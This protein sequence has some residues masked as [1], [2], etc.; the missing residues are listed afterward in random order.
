LIKLQRLN[1]S[2]PTLSGSAPQSQDRLDGAG[3]AVRLVGADASWQ[4]SGVEPESPGSQ[5]QFAI[6]VQRHD[7]R[8]TFGRHSGNHRRV[9]L[10]AKMRFPRVVSRVKQNHPLR[11]LWID[12][13][14]SIAFRQVAGRTGERAVFAAVGTTLDRRDD[15]LQVE[16]ITAGGLGRA[17]VLAP[18]SGTYFH[19]LAQFADL[20]LA[21]ASPAIQSPLL[22]GEDP[23]VVQGEFL[24]FADQVLQFPLFLAAEFTLVV[25]LHE[26]IEPILLVRR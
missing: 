21:H 1:R 22:L 6:Q 9:I 3:S 24:R 20:S 19:T 10:P 13:R 16:A 18:A 26:P 14:R 4:Q 25:F 23:G 7:G 15:V 8:A 2:T 11:R 5:P 12:A 17:T